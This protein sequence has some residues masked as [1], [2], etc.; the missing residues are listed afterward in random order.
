MEELDLMLSDMESAAPLYRPTNFWESGLA[1]IVRDLRTNGFERFRE[2]ESARFFYVPLHSMSIWQRRKRLVSLV[3][4]AMG[5]IS[6]NSAGR[7]REV[8]SGTR[9][10]R[11][12]Y[13][14]FL[15][16]NPTAGLPLDVSESAVGAGERF[17]VNGRLYSRSF[18]NYLRG[19]T[20]L[21]KLTNTDDVNSILEIGGG[22]GTLGE[23]L[24]KSRPDGFYVDVDI[25]PVA[26]VASYY[27]KQVFGEHA[28]L[29]YEQSRDMQT[30]DLDELRKSYRAVVLCAWQLPRVKGCVDVFA[31]FISFQEMEPHV[32]ANYV[33][34]VQ[35]LVRKAVLLRNSVRGKVVASKPGEI[36]VLEQTTTNDIIRNFDQFELL[37][38]DSAVFG[39]ENWKGTFRSEVLCMQRAS[40]NN[41]IESEEG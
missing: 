39:E 4:A 35:P 21:K 36:G 30:I 25:P 15:A 22:Y 11:E 5:T 6:K 2:H 16:A 1:S 3:L 17:E 10:A 9:R 26:A 14:L 24:L 23:I 13:R 18:L 27:L 33:K 31:N 7:L 38:R 32:V 8:I 29:G 20:F 40:S 37:G 28:V 19:L 34:V 41:G 12:E